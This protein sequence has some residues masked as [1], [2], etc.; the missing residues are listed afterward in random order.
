MI[1]SE[2]YGNSFPF[3]PLRILPNTHEF[4]RITDGHIR[5]WMDGTDVDEPDSGFLI[6]FHRDKHGVGLS[7]IFK[8]LEGLEEWCGRTD[9]RTRFLGIIPEFPKKKTFFQRI[10]EWLRG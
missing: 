4:L 2:K 7:P 8:D 10:K 6:M 9:V 5:M 1:D 3:N